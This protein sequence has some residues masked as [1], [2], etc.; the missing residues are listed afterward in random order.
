VDR[1]G[2]RKGFS[3][4]GHRTVVFIL[5]RGEAGF[6]GEIVVLRGQT[7][8]LLH[9]GEVGPQFGRPRDGVFPQAVDLFCHLVQSERH[10]R[11]G[12]RC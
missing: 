5:F 3:R 1:F 9:L 6:L 11:P 8:R 10:G 12:V 2:K 4:G 7:E